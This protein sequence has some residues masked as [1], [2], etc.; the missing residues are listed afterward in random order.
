M[1]S[2]ATKR[3]HDYRNNTD[4]KNPAMPSATQ[5][6]ELHQPFC[7][8]A[9]VTEKTTNLADQVHEAVDQVRIDDAA[10][11]ATMVIGRTMKSSYSSSK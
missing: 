5:R 7:T 2:R 3:L 6:V 1:A 9:H 4:S 11:M 10:N 8:G